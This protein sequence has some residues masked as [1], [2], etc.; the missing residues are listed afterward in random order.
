M[1]V[2]DGSPLQGRHYTIKPLKD[3]IQSRVEDS[4]DRGINHPHRSG[5]RI[6]IH[7]FADGHLIGQVVHG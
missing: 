4:R 1:L 5:G 7:M 3:C 2:L 6:H